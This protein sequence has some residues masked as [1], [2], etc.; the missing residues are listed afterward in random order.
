[1]AKINMRDYY[2]FYEQDEFVEVSDELAAEMAQWERTESTQRRKVYRYHANYSL[3]WGDEIGR[4]VVLRDVAPDE[5]YEKRVTSE[6]LYAAMKALP[7]RQCHRIYAYYILKISQSE[8]ARIDGVDHRTV[9]ISIQR[10]LRNLERYLKKF[11][12][13]VPSCCKICHEQ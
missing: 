10:G 6:Q 2:P 8:I 9:N 5:Y 4:H 7:E 1:M 11:F 13:R 3:D 12:E